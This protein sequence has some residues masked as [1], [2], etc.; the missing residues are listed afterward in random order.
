LQDFHGT[1]IY[2]YIQSRE[3]ETVKCIL[4]LMVYNYNS[5][6]VSDKEYQTIM[7]YTSGATAFEI[8]AFVFM[9]LLTRKKFKLSIID[10][11]TRELLDNSILLGIVFIFIFLFFDELH[12]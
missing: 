9:E 8:V 7:I 5:N 2:S 4:D 11:A 3:K 10:I 1:P 6:K 12:K